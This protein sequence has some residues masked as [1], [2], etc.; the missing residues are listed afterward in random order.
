MIVRQSTFSEVLE[1]LVAAPVLSLD[2]ETFGLRVYQED[3]VFSLILG[4]GPENFYFNLK[5]YPGLD[6]DILSGPEVVLSA[7]QDKIFS[8]PTKKYF[9]HNAKF[10]LAGLSRFGIALAGE[11][12]CTQAIAR[13]IYNEHMEYSLESCAERIGLKKDDKVEEYI[14]A[15]GLWSYEQIPGKKTRSKRKFFDRVP[16]EI[17]ST[18]G[19]TDADITYHL[20]KH[21]EAALQDILNRTPEGWP[22]LAK[23]VENEK[24]FTKTCF[25][26][27]RIGVKIDP[28][29]CKKAALYES[30]RAE[31]V[32]LEFER[33][34]HI[35]FKD[36]N[37]VLAEAFTKLGEKF[38]L[39][40][41]G[42]PSFEHSVLSEFE[43][44]V[45]KL[46][47]DFRD[48][49]SKANYYHGFLYFMDRDHRV[50]PNIRQGGAATGR[51]AQSEP[52]FQNLTKEDSEADLAQEFL[53]RRAIVPTPGYF[54]YCP[55]QDQV[56]YRL[57]LELAARRRGEMTPL[58]QSVLSG[59]DVHEAT[60]QLT[61]Q[62][63]FPIT[64]SQA[65]T[66][67]FLTLY[68]GGREKLAK[69][70]GC[71]P[72]I[73]RQIQDAI[74]QAAPEV[75][76]FIRSVIE[77]ASHRGFIF[78]WLGRRSHFPDSNF[79]YKA[80]NYLI[81]GGCADIMKVAQNKIHQYLQ[82]KK[83]RMLV[84]VHDELLFEIHESEEHICSEI[85]T[86]LENVF[87]SRFLPLTV[88]SAY[89]TLSWADK[90]DGEKTRDSIQSAYQPAFT[91][92]PLHSSI[93]H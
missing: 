80:P 1:K 52:N 90:I 92:A 45:A 57:M 35:P 83:S 6:S 85:K 71:S 54:F 51:T 91:Q 87:P 53:V 48:A 77:I 32:A 25:E 18:Y 86:I 24:Q 70:L 67:N 34:T 40:E 2:T 33:L 55:D 7:L 63:G 11:I 89:A 58:I 23:V 31:K 78:N 61:T 21:Q 69:G 41:K 30:S 93:S 37:K 20:G 42:N 75:R 59:L 49:R 38:P 73:A 76:S 27:E 79:S 47:L 84:Q 17:I 29:Y 46:V 19:E 82:G 60:A 62:A 44:P 72:E 26:M 65:K 12:H 9:L 28:E 43:S 64:R 36:S 3:K 15:N 74:F 14:N 10:D 13:V 16:F 81:Q 5:E 66:V 4:I 68:G 56:E 8:D 50:H 39:T 88:G 22:S